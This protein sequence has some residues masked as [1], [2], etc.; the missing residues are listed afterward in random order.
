[1]GLF[2]RTKKIDVATL[3]ARLD[4]R[5]RLV[6]IDV[7]EP[8]EWRRGR[9]GVSNNVPLRQLKARLSRIPLDR[10]VVTVCASGHRSAAAAR[11]LTRAGF[12]AENLSGGVRAWSRAGLPLVRR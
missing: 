10:P 5:Q 3:A 11:I 7:R 4:D 9:I 2:T 6:I 12:D 1:M 8:H